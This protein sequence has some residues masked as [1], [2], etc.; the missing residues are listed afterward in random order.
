MLPGRFLRTAGDGDV[1]VVGV[2]TERV[3]YN[4]GDDD[5]FICPFHLIH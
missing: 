1:G 2:D 3:Y 5:E 4:K